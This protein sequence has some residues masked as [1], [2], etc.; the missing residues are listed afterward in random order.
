LKGY[1]SIE[2]K[3][4]E[5]NMDDKEIIALYNDRNEKAIEETSTKY[6]KFCYTIAYNILSDKEDSEEC[7]NDTWLG[8]WN[9]IPP[10]Q[11]KSLKYY[12]AGIVRN[13]SLKLFRNKHRE[14]RNED[15]VSYVLDEIEEITRD[16]VTIEDEVG[17]HELEKRINEFL[18]TLTEKER[19]VFLRRYYFM[20]PIK[21]ISKKSGMS[22]NGVRVSLSRTRTKMKEYLTKEGY[23]I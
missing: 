4:V 15:N 13:L 2:E 5:K 18:K 1:L 3:G 21:D 10:T 22:E 16:T 7:L 6:G 20:D 19:C 12:L 23:G 17:A 14:K 9:T 8:A 11:P